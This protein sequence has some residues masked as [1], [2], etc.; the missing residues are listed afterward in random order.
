[1]NPRLFLMNIFHKSFS[2]LKEKRALIQWH[3]IF[4]LCFSFAF[5]RDKKVK[6]I[7]ENVENFWEKSDRRHEPFK[8]RPTYFATHLEEKICIG[9][10]DY[11]KHT[12]FNWICKK[13]KF[14]THLDLN[15]K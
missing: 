15:H 2:F 9:L 14:V 12:V 1:M 7:F 3:V 4:K 10:I 13:T 8:L 5:K 6:C 11:S